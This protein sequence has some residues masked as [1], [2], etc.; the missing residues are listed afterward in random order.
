VDVLGEVEPFAGG[1]PPNVPRRFV[2][3][4]PF[5]LFLWRDQA[6]WPYFGAWIGDD[7]AMQAFP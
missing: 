7:S 1:P 6:E 4:R 3:D 5:F 2:Y